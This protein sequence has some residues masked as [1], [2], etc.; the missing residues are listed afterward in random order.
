MFGGSKIDERYNDLWIFDLNTQI[1]NELK[2]KGNIPQVIKK[3]KKI[4][5]N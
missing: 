1:W 5:F 2:P 3:Y 4:F